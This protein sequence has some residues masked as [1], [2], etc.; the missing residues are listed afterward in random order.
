MYPERP[1]TV[2][3]DNNFNLLYYASSA[4]AKVLVREMDDVQS[5]KQVIFSPPLRR[6]DG[7]GRVGESIVF[8]GYQVAFEEDDLLVFVAK[9]G[10]SER[11]PFNRDG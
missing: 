1:L 3:R 8:A 2:T 4:D 11:I 9:V 5:I 6:R 10:L 7:V